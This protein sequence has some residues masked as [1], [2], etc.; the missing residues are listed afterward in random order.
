MVLQNPHDKV[1][2]GDAAGLRRYS[3]ANR[4]PNPVSAQTIPALVSSATQLRLVESEKLVA[5]A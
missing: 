2:G 1:I 4:C 5:V 3:T